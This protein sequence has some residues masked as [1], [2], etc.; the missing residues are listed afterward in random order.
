MA[1]GAPKPGISDVLKSKKYQADNEANRKTYDI[2]S[3]KGRRKIDAAIAEFAQRIKEGKSLTKQEQ[4]K[5]G[6]LQ[7]LTRQIEQQ[8]EQDPD[9]EV[10]RRQEVEERKRQFAEI[11]RQKEQREQQKSIEDSLAVLAEI[12]KEKQEK[13]EADEGGLDALKALSEELSKWKLSEDDDDKKTTGSATPTPSRPGSPTQTG[14][15]G[16]A[17]A[18][19]GGP[20]DRRPTG[21]AGTGAASGGAGGGAGRAGAGGDPGGDSDPDSDDDDDKM[22]RPKGN[23]INNIPMFDGTTP[24]PERWLDAVERVAKTFDW[25]DDRIA[26]A[27]CLRMSDKAAL[28]LESLVRTDQM[29]AL[30]DKTYEDFKKVFIARFKPLDEAIKATE[31]IM[32]L[33]MKSNESVTEFADRITI[34]VEKKNATW[35]DATKK[36]KEYKDNRSLDMFTFMCAGLDNSLRRVVM[37]GSDP[38][39]NFEDLLKKA[40]S[41]EAALKAKHSIQELVEGMDAAST[42]DETPPEDPNTAKI[43]ALEK[44]IEAMKEGIK[45][46]FCSQVGH[47]K[48]FCPKFKQQQQSGNTR[49]RGGGG[50]GRGG[51]QGRGGYQG[52][53]RGGFRGNRGGNWRGRGGGRGRGGYVPA[54]Y[55]GQPGYYQ[56]GYQPRYPG[57]QQVQQGYGSYGP[58][59]QFQQQQQQQ[60]APHQ[61]YEIVEMPG[62]Y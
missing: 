39:T 59:Q 44:Q 56:Q 10:R 14:A 22:G 2:H 9:E 20:G 62:N 45:C 25:A 42:T 53:W 11:L 19:G 46:W 4:D 13:G 60:Q 3:T 58:P 49:G 16:G 43:Q 5:Y 31:A 33:Q 30:V 51:F 17:G 35:D 8:Q 12:E 27:A 57:V 52:N 38:P 61:Q 29:E 18:A 32:G 15:A 6:W 50:R 37:G 34:G 55:F 21:G 7:Q 41:A 47:T 1:S 26:K 28:W 23:E 24:D 48:K 36:T 40:V 54:A